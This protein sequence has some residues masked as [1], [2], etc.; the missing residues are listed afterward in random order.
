MELDQNNVLSALV[1]PSTR[2][3]RSFFIRLALAVAILLLL[4]FLTFYK[5]TISPPSDFPVKKYIEIEKGLS[6]DETAAFLKEKNI[7]RFTPMFR[8]FVS[9]FGVT[10]NII[11]GEYRF[12]EP[13]SL[14]DVVRK[15]TDTEYGGRAVKITIPE[16]FTNRDIA[17]LLDGKLSN[18]NKDNF[19]KVALSQEGYLF[20]DTYIFPI[21]YTEENIITRMHDNFT[22][23]IADIKQE[24]ISSKRTLGELVIMASILEKEARTIPTRK[25]ISGILWKRFD[26]G[27]L[28]Q[29]DAS[30]LYLFNKESSELTGSDLNTDSR[31]NTYKYKGLPPGAISNP[32][33]DAIIAALRPEE[34]KFWF[35]L[36]DKEGNMHY[37]VTFDEHVKN[38]QR[39]LYK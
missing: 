39:Y 27:G 3:A 13:V 29:V 4:I 34:S 11:A 15:V 10:G 21:I 22:A 35:Y 36:S 1:R 6:I 17:E 31:Y 33:I 32:G 2:P 8:V 19:M 30:F 18:F 14:Y 5:F 25:K 12:E 28:L 26:A 24:I 7:I 38:K 23:K 20:P 16:G 9:L 37:A